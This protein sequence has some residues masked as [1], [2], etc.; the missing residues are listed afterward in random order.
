MA[1]LTREDWLAAA[2]RALLHGGP[3]AVRVDTLARQLK[4]SRG[5]FYW[6]FKDRSDLLAALLAEWEA[7]KSLLAAV[8]LAGD[9]GRG[10]Q[11]FFAE[12]ERRTVASE[13]GDWPSDAAI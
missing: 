4:I 12:L 11:L 3:A 9:R 1:D 2:R 6:H 7:E 5:S 13:R 8:L 10:L